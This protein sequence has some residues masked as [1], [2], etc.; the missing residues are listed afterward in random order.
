M[1][2]Y[3]ESDPGAPAERPVVMPART[4]QMEDV[5]IQLTGGYFDLI[6]AAWPRRRFTLAEFPGIRYLSQ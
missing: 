6:N 4:A 2:I 3:M 1:R 5:S